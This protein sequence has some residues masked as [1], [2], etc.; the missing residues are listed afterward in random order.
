MLI[1][2]YFK[3]LH[4][5]SC[6]L[7][8]LHYSTT[9]VYILYFRYLGTLKSKLVI[10][11]FL[12]SGFLVILNAKFP[13]LLDIHPIYLL[14]FQTNPEEHG[15]QLMVGNQRFRQFTMGFIT[16]TKFKSRFKINPGLKPNLKPDQI[17]WVWV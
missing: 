16:M 11:N 5:C 15:F 12:G 1:L 10:I 9:I 6:N 7:S 8:G 14:W 17:N 13:A 2:T 3:C 4:L